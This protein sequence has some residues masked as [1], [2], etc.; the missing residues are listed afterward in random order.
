MDADYSQI[1]LRIMAHLSR[2]PA[3]VAAFTEGTDVHRRTAARIYGVNEGEV[4]AE[5]RGRAKTI[6]FGVMYGMGPRGLSKAL[7]ISIE[8]AKAFIAEYFERHPG[9][10]EYIDRTIEEAAET[11]CAQTLLGRRRPLPD[12][13][14]EDGRMKSFAERTA[15][16]MPIQGTA[17]DLI[18]IAMID[19]DR[20]MTE[21]GLRGRMILQVHD[22]LVFDIPPS[23]R[24]EMEEI[25]RT[26]MEGA[27]EL[28][29]PLVVDIG[30]GRN[31]LEAH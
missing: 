7:G 9:V 26:R 12:I 3:L 27:V 13:D 5:M 14:G 24:E 8:E 28:A 16:N 1:E 30:T 19:I 15:V 10:R 6:N 31:W 2:D 20:A 25:V 29:V 17:A 18:K 11:R 21:R 22:E 4:D 23:E